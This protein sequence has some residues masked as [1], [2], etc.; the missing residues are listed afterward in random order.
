MTRESQ[1]LREARI[2]KGYTQMEV[3]ACAGVDIRLYQRLEYGQRSIVRASL[4]TGLAICFVL[5]LDSM[6]LVFGEGYTA[7][8]LMRTKIAESRSDG[9]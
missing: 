2:R 9:R 8:N 5:D 3:A 1:M 6:E 7:E 4:K